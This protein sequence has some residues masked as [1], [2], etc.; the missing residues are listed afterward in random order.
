[1]MPPN[2]PSAPTP[3]SS[4]SIQPNTAPPPH[5]QPHLSGVPLPPPQCLTPTAVGSEILPSS[6]ILLQSAH[7]DD[8]CPQHAM[9]SRWAG[10]PSTLDPLLPWSL[11][12][13]RESS[14]VLLD[15]RVRARTGSSPPAPR[16]CSW[17]SW[18]IAPATFLL[19]LRSSPTAP[20]PH[21]PA[22]K[23]ATPTKE[24]SALYAA[25]SHLVQGER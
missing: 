19:P 10:T 9:D 2:H 15:T 23:Q 14:H 7:R 22:R 25:Q 18:P 8:A 24:A 1:M 12:R 3:S 17:S 20:L 5:R 11:T 4:S 13:E 16:R 21:D 6:F